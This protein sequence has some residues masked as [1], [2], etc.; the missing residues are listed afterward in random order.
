MSKNLKYYKQILQKVS[1][2]VQL[3]RKELQKAYTYLNPEDQI[4]LRRWVSEYVSNRA[5][6]KLIYLSV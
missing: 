4:L 6:L 2:D 5:D 3:F 1:F